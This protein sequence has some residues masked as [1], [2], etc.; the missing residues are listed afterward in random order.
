MSASG[1]V[2]RP[3]AAAAAPH[4]DV[5]DVVALLATVQGRRPA[6][7]HVVAIAPPGRRCAAAR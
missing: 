3:E 1:R 2:G 4:V 5:R 7:L 6:A